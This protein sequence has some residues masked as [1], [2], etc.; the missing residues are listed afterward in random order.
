MY[1]GL[2]SAVLGIL[3]MGSCF[4]QTNVGAGS[5]V[6][7]LNV[8]E[9]VWL[10]GSY[11]NYNNYQWLIVGKHPGYAKK[12]SL[13]RFQDIPSG[14]KTVNHAMMYLYYIYSHKASWQTVDQAPFITRTVQA[15]RVPRSWK[16]T[17]ATSTK[18][19]SGYKWFAQYLGLD[20]TDANDCPT[21]QAT[22]YAYRPSGFV[23][24]EVTSAVKDW[25]AGKPNYGLLIWATNEDQNGRDTRFYSKS[26]RDSSKHP[27]IILNCN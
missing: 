19:L 9:D 17:Q 22:I 1:V 6:Y 5:T 13:L 12:R 3:S 23:E 11:S 20:D 7:K 24:F 15:H 26:Y 25:K 27:Y 16:E 21:G 14:C 2:F 18:R 4:A 10:E 8:V